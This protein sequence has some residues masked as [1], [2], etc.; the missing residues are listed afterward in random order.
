MTPKEK[1]ER[2]DKAIKEITIPFLREQGFNGS[3]PHFRRIQTDRINLLTFQHSLHDAKF[4]VE[5]ANCP[6]GGITT[7]WEKKLEPHECNAHYMS[8]R[9]RIGSEKHKTDYWFDY[10]R[11]TLFT[12]IYKR[13]AKEIIDYWEEAE[14]W[15]KNDPFQQRLE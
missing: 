4:V 1:R 12:D 10:G 2:I 5:I 14:Q 9:L 15:W 13:R 8:H 11:R 3:L 7:F 6:I